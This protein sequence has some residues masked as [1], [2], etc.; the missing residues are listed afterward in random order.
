MTREGKDKDP[1]RD[2]G[3]AK[4]AEPASKRQK[5]RDERE[6]EAAERVADA[7]DVIQSR[8]AGGIRIGE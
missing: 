4:A 6:A 2:K 5:T 3:K 7:F 1:R 8:R